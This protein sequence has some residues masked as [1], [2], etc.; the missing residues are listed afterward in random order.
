MTPEALDLTP[1]RDELDELART[2]PAA[3]GSSG[4]PI[5]RRAAAL[6]QRLRDAP[7]I[8]EPAAGE[9]TG[10]RLVPREAV[11]EVSCW[12]P[13]EG[14][15]CHLAAVWDAGSLVYLV[16]RSGD[17]FWGARQTPAG[18][19]RASAD[20]AAEGSADRRWF[21]DLERR[22]REV[23]ARWKEQERRSTWDCVRCAWR[24]EELESRCA[25]CGAPGVGFTGL[26]AG[27][28]ADPTGDASDPADDRYGWDRQPAGLPTGL[29]RS[30]R[31]AAEGAELTMP[32]G[33]EVGPADL[34]S[35]R[36]VPAPGAPLYDVVLVA[37]PERQ[38]S[39]VSEAVREIGAVVGQEVDRARRAAWLATLPA[40][41]CRGVDVD[42]AETASR[43]LTMAGATAD[44]RKHRPGAGPRHGG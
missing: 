37:F 40:V 5:L 4:G 9:W 18:E 17:C 30:G 34:A 20:G 14:A 43:L 6:L 19:S 12:S 33:L 8:G 1:F 23:L 24:N 32:P 31:I 15:E 3:A 25:L 21:A 41:I 28:L 36:R 42:D 13:P 11:V 26:A 22:S 16:V 44:V 35:T 7:V 27:G 38:R 10:M 2:A 39:V 29:P